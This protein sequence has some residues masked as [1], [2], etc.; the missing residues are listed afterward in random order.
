MNKIDFLAIQGKKVL[1]DTNIIMKIEDSSKDVKELLLAFATKNNVC[2]CDTVLYELLRNLNAQRFRERHNL[3]RTAGLNCISEGTPAVKAMFERISWLYFSYLRKEPSNFLHRKQ[4][5]LW[6]ISAGLANG[7]RYFL[8]TDKSADFLPALFTTKRF[9]LDK[10]QHI[11][12]HEFNNQAAVDAWRELYTEE[13]CTIRLQ[14]G[15]LETIKKQ[16]LLLYGS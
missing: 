3:I 4:N 10:K 5:D 2:I 11:C 1:L 14:K 8:T 13:S 7:I 16:S 12:L 15:Y 9:A 6:I